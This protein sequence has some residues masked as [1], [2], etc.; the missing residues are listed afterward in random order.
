MV[1]TL[2]SNAGC[3]QGAKIPRASWSKNPNVKQ[4]QHYNKFSNGLH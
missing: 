2:P 3:G 4:K 1:K